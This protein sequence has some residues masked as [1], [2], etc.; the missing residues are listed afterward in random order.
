M[1]AKNKNGNILRNN[2]FPELANQTILC[3][4]EKNVKTTTGPSE[5]PSGKPD[6]H[7]SRMS[8][9]TDKSSTIDMLSFRK[10]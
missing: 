7:L 2:S 10:T 1:L 6:S 5:K 3:N 9:K 4:V 8:E